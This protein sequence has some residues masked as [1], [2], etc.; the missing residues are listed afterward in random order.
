[1]STEV[2][3]SV[4]D[5]GWGVFPGIGEGAKGLGSDWWDGSF[6][7]PGLFS[8]FVTA[9]VLIPVS[10]PEGRVLFLREFGMR[11]RSCLS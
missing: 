5:G 7:D 9:K 8:G 3:F 2:C 1:M 4:Q 10:G 6:G 11:E